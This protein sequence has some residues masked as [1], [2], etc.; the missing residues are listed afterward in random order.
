[1]AQNPNKIEVYK[2]A[3]EL[4]V[5]VYKE[6]EKMKVVF[7]I[8]DQLT[9]S[10]TSIG[11]NLAEFAALDNTNQQRQKIIV[12]IGEANEAEYWL[13]FCKNVGHLSDE[14]HKELVNRL[15]PIRMMLYNLKERIG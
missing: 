6:V 15:K 10:V 5:D 3:K 13:D 1:M 8:K 11:A 9:G 14:R 4:A 2:Q 12:A 7:R